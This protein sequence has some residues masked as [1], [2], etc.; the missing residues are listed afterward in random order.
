M[1]ASLLN[2][3]A[4]LPKVKCL[5]VY[6]CY[7]PTTRSQWYQMLRMIIPQLRA[8]LTQ[9]LVRSLTDVSGETIV[10]WDCLEVYEGPM[11][12]LSCFGRAS[13]TRL[14][15]LV[16]TETLL[17]LDQ[18][19]QVADI[20]GNLA[21]LNELFLNVVELDTLMI[22][23]LSQIASGLQELY[24]E[25]GYEDI[26]TIVFIS[27]TDVIRQFSRLRRL[28]LFS[29]VGEEGTRTKL[30]EEHVSNTLMRWRIGNGGNLTH[31]RMSVLSIWEWRESAN[32]WQ[33][34]VEPV[35]TID[36]RIY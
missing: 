26:S 19:F 13:F 35:L 18:L 25:S 30:D 11:S 2:R 3:G 31:V 8:S 12:L 22:R 36:Q 23:K 24:I 32:K 7:W 34:R 33:S 29:F 14:T 16:I 10:L 20:A 9:L 28:S 1:V 4:H 27:D 15:T 21:F 17:D 5:I 6:D